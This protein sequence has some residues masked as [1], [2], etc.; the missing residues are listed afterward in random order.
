MTPSQ[1]VANPQKIVIKVLIRAYKV[2][3]LL[4]L[5]EPLYEN[6]NQLKPCAEIPDF[7]IIQP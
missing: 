1:A 4:V 6:T 7:G 3:T 5:Q 2:P